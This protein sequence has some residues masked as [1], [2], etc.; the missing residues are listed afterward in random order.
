MDEVEQ[1]V[2]GLFDTAFA[3]TIPTGDADRPLTRSLAMYGVLAPLYSQELW[4]L[5]TGAI[6][7]AVDGDGSQLLALADSFWHRTADG[8][9]DNQVA[10]NKAVICID[11]QIAPEPDSVPTQDDF[12]AASPLFGETYY[13]LVVVECDDWPIQPSVESPDPTTPPPSRTSPS[14][15]PSP[16]ADSSSGWPLRPSTAPPVDRGAHRP[17]RLGPGSDPG[18]ARV[19]RRPS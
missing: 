5:L 13:G 10:S 16:P 19:E 17:R 8:Y 3:E 2:S 11:S 12:I 14:K 18:R 6:S 15:P 7:A 4:T 1:V 9:A